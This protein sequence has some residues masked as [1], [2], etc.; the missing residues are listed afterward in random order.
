MLQRLFRHRLTLG[1]LSCACRKHGI[2]PGNETTINNGKR[3]TVGEFLKDSSQPQQFIL[4]QK[5]DN[6]GELH[7]SLLA[8]DKTG[9]VFSLASASPW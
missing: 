7:L 4:N 9:H 1:T 2:L 3:L 8:V 6:V 5:R